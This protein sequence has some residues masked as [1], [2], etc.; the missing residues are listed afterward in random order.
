MTPFVPALPP[1]VLNASRTFDVP[2]T[3][4]RSLNHWILQRASIQAITF[5]SG[6]VA[7][8]VAAAMVLLQF[9]P[10]AGVVFC[11]LAVSIAIAA[12]VGGYHYVADV[13]LAFVIAVLI[14]AAFNGFA[15]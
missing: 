13:L 9:V 1:R 14:F 15:N 10:L 4:I 12:V 8:A 7:A 2:S 5:P 6:H 3:R 11:W